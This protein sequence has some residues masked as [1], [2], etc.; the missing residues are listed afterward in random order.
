M[1]RDFF[2]GWEIPTNSHLWVLRII[3][4]N[5]KPGVSEEIDPSHTGEEIRQISAKNLNDPDFDLVYLNFGENSE[6]DCDVI[7]VIAD[8]GKH[9]IVA[10]MSGNC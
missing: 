7:E 8:D 10:I 4:F 5:L 1:D 9:K 6:A 3:R 2:V